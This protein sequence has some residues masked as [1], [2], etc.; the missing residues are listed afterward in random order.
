LR[1][2]IL[3]RLPQPRQTSTPQCNP[4]SARTPSSS[5]GG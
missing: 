3:P 2:A 5:S 4:A 1:A